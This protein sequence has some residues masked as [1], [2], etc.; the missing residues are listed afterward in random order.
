MQQLELAVHRPPATLPVCA[1]NPRLTAVDGSLVA[2]GG[3]LARAVDGASWR[4]QQ[5]VRNVEENKLLSC[6][7]RFSYM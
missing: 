2:V 1:V 4:E 5:G 6:M 3:Q 7:F